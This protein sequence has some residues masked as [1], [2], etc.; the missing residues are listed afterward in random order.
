VDA[1]MAK[2]K[3]ADDIV[4][5][6]VEAFEVAQDAST[7]NHEH[8]KEDVRFARLSEQWPEQLRKEREV[9]G[10]PCLTI[11]KL[12]SVIRQVVNDARQNRPA[13]KVLPCDSKADPETAEVIAG[14]IRNIEASSDADVAYDTAVDCAAS[15]GFGYWSINVDYAVN[16][17]SDDQ[18]EGFGASAFEKDIFIRRIANPLSVF[19]DPYSEAADSSDWMQAHIV[20]RIKKEDFEDK[21]PK[22]EFTD[23][24]AAQWVNIREPWNDGDT[25]QIAEYW[26][27]EPIQKRAVMLQMPDSEDGVGEQLILMADDP[28][29]KQAMELG[30]QVIAERQ[31][32]AFKVCQYVV[33]GVELL[34]ENDWAGSYIPIVPV[35]GDE[36][37]FEGRRHFR[38]LICDAKDPQQNF[39]YW[40]ST[41]TET[42]ALAPRVPF[43]ID[44]D[45]IPKGEEKKW[46]TANSSSHP[47]LKV[48]KGAA[49]SRQTSAQ[50][51][52]GIMQEALNAADDIKA[53]T[54]IYDASLGA[55]S[56]ETSG[57]AIRTRQMEGDISTFHFIDNLTRAIRHSGRILVDLIPKVYNTERVIRILGEDGSA[58]AKPI[59]APY[60]VKPATDDQDAI[61]A[62]HDLRVGRYDVTVTAGPGYTTRRQEAAE[63]MM[64][65]IQSYP[66]AAPII[67]DLLAKNLD[68]PGADE[69]AKR[70]EKMLPPNLRD[71]QGG[72]DPAIQQQ[73]QQMAQ[74]LQMLQGE[75]QKASDKRDLDAAK[76]Q[77]DAYKAATERMA[78][79][80][81]AFGPNE[82]A[83]VV[84]QTLAEVASEMLPNEEAAPAGPGPFGQPAMGQ[85]A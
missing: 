74:A 8:Y 47:Y 64:N 19:G 42:I 57:V 26:K 40:R 32:K 77:I 69:I 79:I 36:V 81:P 3:P 84:R 17:I 11:N 80:A 35:Y 31:V 25:V 55:R 23:F 85:A 2:Q 82:V 53:V 24:S 1:L 10:K 9:Q 56:N 48:K 76:V 71:D 14:I 62:M 52:T 54:G 4:K 13:S 78:A 33:N 15:G 22:A 51:P 60:Q 37:N 61:M 29:A 6:A 5:E 27:R 18:L 66:D 72:V 43:I 49:W 20:S 38:S 46:S 83:A 30:A 75:L 50:I 41:A 34:E 70:L 39:N 45:A 67:G 7:R 73:L 21:Y 16:A 65:L 68:W 44:E 58:D 28:A 59:N 63:Q 12:Q